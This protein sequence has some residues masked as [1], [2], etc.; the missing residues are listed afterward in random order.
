[1]PD[2]LKKHYDLAIVGGG[3]VGLAHALSAGRQGLSV[4]VFE[5]HEKPRGASKLNFGMLWPIGQNPGEVRRR[6]L[7]S[8]DI[9]QELFVEAGIWNDPCGSLLLARREEELAVLE[10]FLPAAEQQGYDCDLL[11][12]A[13]TAEV[14]PGVRQEGL[15]GALHSRQEI[16]VDPAQALSRLASFLRKR[17][18]TSFHYGTEV[19]RVT[20]PAV[21]TT[22]G[23]FHAD[24]V[25]I[26]GGADFETLFPEAF[27]ASG[28][29]RCKL[30][31]LKTAPQPSNWKLGAMVTDGLTFRRY[32]AFRDCPSYPRLQETILAEH[33]ELDRL[34]ITVLAA[35]NGNAEI[36]FGDSHHYAWTPPGTDD[37]GI[38][39]KIIDYLRG[40]VE[41]PHLDISERWSAVYSSH[42]QRTEVILAPADSTRIVLASGGNGLTTS[43]AL[44]E[45]T[46]GNW[47]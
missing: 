6:A 46:F 23:R 45:E 4:A 20:A 39:R 31:M 13:E 17:L 8:L 9:W 40:L 26:C 3:I 35:Q 15:L 2:S 36:V 24:R 27:R 1:M 32:Q 14:A 18:G 42:P 41:L 16:L 28:I 12:P 43:F 34:G 44:A 47:S 25:L 30:Q 11:D 10:E 38:D 29:T 37:P 19:H 21:E 22:A 7:R 33:G 5:R